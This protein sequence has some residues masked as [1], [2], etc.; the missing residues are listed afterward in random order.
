MMRGR[1]DS[2]TEAQQ[3]RECDKDLFHKPPV[4]RRQPFPEIHSGLNGRVIC[5]RLSRDRHVPLSI[6]GTDED[7]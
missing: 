7:Q 5:V 2:A 3:Q 1:L 6:A 4:R